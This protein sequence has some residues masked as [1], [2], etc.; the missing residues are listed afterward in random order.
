MDTSMNVTEESNSKM[1]SNMIRLA[2]KCEVSW[3]VLESFLDE[4]SS[5][6]VKSKQ[7]IRILLKEFKI[8]SKNSTKRSVIKNKHEVEDS[9]EYDS[10]IDEATKES[11][12][13][14]DPESDSITPE[15]QNEIENSC[16]QDD[17]DTLSNLPKDDYFIACQSDNE[18]V[19]N[20]LYS[21]DLKS[22]ELVEEF[23]DQLYTFI[24]N[25]VE[26]YDKGETNYDNQFINLNEDQGKEENE[27]QNKKMQFQCKFCQK[28]FKCSSKL[29]IHERIHT[30]EVPFGCK[31][32]N[33]RFKHSSALKRHERIHTGEVPY[34]CKTC[35]K[36]FKQQSVLKIHERNIQVKNHTSAKN[37]I[38]PSNK[39][40]P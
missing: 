39:Q 37:V 9:K 35:K 32:C 18:V 21:Q 24:G 1:I 14:K 13:E 11:E 12:Q 2:M 15:C 31:I 38:K 4:M 27:K 19:G 25:D 22:I 26:A 20:R 5:S 40:L 23:K 29:K 17:K 3:T 28:C 36:R 8:L 7:V 33:K 10:L 30:G 16:I 34:Q 6:L